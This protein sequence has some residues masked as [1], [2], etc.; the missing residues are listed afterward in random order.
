MVHGD[1]VTA[2]YHSILGN[3]KFAEPDIEE[4]F[5]LSGDGKSF[6]ELRSH[7]PDVDLDYQIKRLKEL[8]FLVEDDED[9]QI[10]CWSQR[11]NRRYEK[12]E[13]VR[14]LRLNVSTKCNLACTY[15]YGSNG[16]GSERNALMS[17]DIASRALSLYAKLLQEHNGSI[18]QI[19]YFGGEPFLNWSVMQTNIQQAA[20]LADKLGLELVLGINSNVTL[21]TPDIANFLSM[22]R[23]QLQVFVSLDGPKKEHNKARHYKNGQGSY[24]SV[25]HGL[26]L[27]Q[28]TQIPLAIST[29]L[30]E[31][32][33]DAIPDLIDLLLTRQI[34]S[35]GLNPFV[36]TGGTDQDLVIDAVQKAIDYGLERDFYVSGLWGKVISRLKSEPTGTYCGGSG[37][38][39]S[40]MPNGDIYPCQTQ[41]FL[42][43]T[44][45]TLQNG[46]IF[47]TEIYRE[48]VMRSAGNIP[49]CRGCEIEGLCAGGCAAD[50]YA[51]S[52]N[53]YSRTQ[54]CKFIS[55]MVQS[56]II[57]MQ[58]AVSK[59]F[60]RLTGHLAT[61]VLQ[62]TR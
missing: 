28:E 58:S 12:G 42:L 18:L 37:N 19:R 7:F 4:F 3:L 2:V 27:L 52:D 59:D 49:E 20:D 50:A 25:C 51:M 36:I 11:K 26:D 57:R 23:N 1:V 32:N 39:L 62:E 10:L 24:T 40:V 35:I 6:S 14:A 29:V 46:E 43:G 9:E 30:G 56:Y 15:C 21:I 41:P 13:M 34:H 55:A 17:N 33:I 54:Y 61:T 38:E 47:K 8:K 45:D 60:K 16:E 53:L 44:L 5:L 22:Y 48:V 31:H